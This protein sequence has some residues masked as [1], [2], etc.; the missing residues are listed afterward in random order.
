M[1]KILYILCQCSW[2]LLQT[3]LGAVMF[4]IFV[5]K[6][7]FLHH[8][9]V[10]TR[11]HAKGSASLGMFVFLSDRHS[12]KAE[13]RVLAHE[14]GHTLQSLILGPL[15]L[16]VIALP[17]LVWAGFPALRKMRGRRGI[18]YYRMYTER[19]ANYLEERYIGD[20]TPR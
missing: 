9:A 14:F 8:G 17:S 7:H 19:W 16:A 4:L 12:G 6:P 20:E 5:G 13:E 1:R 11:W 2:G 18:S 3:A 10:V 15:Y